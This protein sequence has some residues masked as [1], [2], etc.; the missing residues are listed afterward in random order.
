MRRGL[1][2]LPS[3]EKLPTSFRDTYSLSLPCEL[4]NLLRSLNK[5]INVSRELESPIRRWAVKTAR[6]LN[7]TRGSGRGLLFQHR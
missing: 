7:K 5:R 4:I 1:N 2:P 3:L 6:V